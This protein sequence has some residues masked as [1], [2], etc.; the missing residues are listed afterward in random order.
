VTFSI[1]NLK[2]DLAVDEGS[3]ATRYR[4]SAGHWTIGVGHN[5]DASPL[6]SGWREPLTQTQI[7]E[8][9]SR[10]VS[11]TLAGLDQHLPGWRSRPEPVARSLAN[12]A[13]NLGVAGLLGFTTFLRLISEGR[14][15]DAASD[16]NGTLWARQVGARATRIEALLRSAR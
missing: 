8:L 11:R 3:R 5:L 13:Y 16:L 1:T 12:M 6:P 9:F 10:D 7:D 14:Y 2:R 4:D 15:A